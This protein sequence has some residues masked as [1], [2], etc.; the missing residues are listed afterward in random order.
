VKHNFNRIV[1]DGIGL[2]LPNEMDLAPWN[3]TLQIEPFLR[4]EEQSVETDTD[5]FWK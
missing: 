2:L 4:G 3:S 5:S 1:Q